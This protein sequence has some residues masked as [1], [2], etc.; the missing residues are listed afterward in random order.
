MAITRSPDLIC[1]ACGDPL[2]HRTAET[3]LIHI[4]EQLTLCGACYA[5]LVHG[6]LPIWTDSLYQ[7][8]GTGTVARQRWGRR[9]TDC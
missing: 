4:K 5:E 2:D 7:P 1:R 6:I 3:D 9:N 8:P